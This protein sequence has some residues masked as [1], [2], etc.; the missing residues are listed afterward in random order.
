[1]KVPREYKALLERLGLKAPLVSKAQKVPQV[2]M[3]LV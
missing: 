1:L 2:T 3:G